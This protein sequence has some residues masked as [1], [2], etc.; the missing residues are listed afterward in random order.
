MERN[1]NFVSE[2]LVKTAEQST[3][4]AEVDAVLHDVGIKLWR[5]VLKGR[6]HSVLD[7]GNGLV[8]TVGDLLIAH[9]HLHRQ[10]CDAVR[11]MNHE[12][13]GSL[14]AKVGES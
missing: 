3:A 14:L 11:T 7:L 8:K 12:V 5:C 13:F 2:T 6:E 9:R 10:G 4:A 1:V